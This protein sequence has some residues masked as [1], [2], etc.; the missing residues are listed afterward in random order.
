VQLDNAQGAGALKFFRRFSI[1]QLHTGLPGGNLK[2]GYH[3]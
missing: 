3:K 1:G 2:I